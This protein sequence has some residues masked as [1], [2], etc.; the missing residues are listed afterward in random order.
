[1]GPS[2]PSM[3]AIF[4]ALGRGARPGTRLPA[5]RALD[6]AP[7]VLALLGVEAP[8]WMEGGALAELLPPEG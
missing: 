2:D 8:A 5:V 7:T 3:A 4:L 1:M 6:V